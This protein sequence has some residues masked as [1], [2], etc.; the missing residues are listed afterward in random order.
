MHPAVANI[1]VA[2]AN[3][4]EVLV[5]KT[6][7]GKAVLGVVDGTAV[8]RIENEEEKAERRKTVEELGYRIE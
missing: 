3:P 4:I 1:Y 7:L 8:T 6:E 2:S 5:A